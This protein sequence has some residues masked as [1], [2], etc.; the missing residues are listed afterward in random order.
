S[1]FKNELAA[2]PFIKGVSFANQLPPKLSWNSAFRKG[3]SEQDYLLYVYR[4]D[5]DHL[6]TMGYEMTAGRFFSREFKSDTAAI[7]LN[8]TAYNAMGFT[9]LEEAEVLT[10]QSDE[11]APLKVIGVLKD[12][13]FHSLK[14]NVKSMAIVLGTEPDYE[15]AIRLAPGNPQEQIKLL[16]SIWQKH[17]AGAPFEYSF[18]DQ[19]FDAMFRAEQRMSQVILIFTIL[20]IGIAC[21]GLFGLAAYTAEQRAKEISIRK[22]MGASA[23]Q[24]MVLMSKDF[25]VLVGIAFVIAAPLAWFLAEQWLQGFA[26]RIEIDFSIV[27]FSGAISLL[28]ALLTISYQSIKAAHEH[29]VKAM[30]SE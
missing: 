3:G 30:R 28:L 18:L 2:H 22:V 20:A 7:I 19:N 11:P 27:I 25:T 15:L 10:Y 23:S 26:N 1:A 16:E 5:H 13:N 29:P 4:V 6:N 24:M 21:L 12:F 14:D 17:A 9:N 8:E